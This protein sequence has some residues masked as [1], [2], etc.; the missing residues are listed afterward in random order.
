MRRSSPLNLRRADAAVLPL[1]KRPSRKQRLSPRPLLKSLLQRRR[2]RRRLKQLLRKSNYLLK[3][4]L[5]RFTASIV[6]LSVLG[7][8]DAFGQIG[9]LFS[10]NV[11]DYPS[12]PGQTALGGLNLTSSF[13]NNNDVLGNPAGQFPVKENA[14]PIQVSANYSSLS[15]LSKMGGAAVR[16]PIKGMTAS[17]GLNY[18]ST[19]NIDGYDVNGMP[20]NDFTASDFVIYGNIS[21]KKGNFVLGANVKLLGSYIENYSA[22]AAAVD[23]GGT[24]VHPIED[25]KVALAVKNIGS[26]LK[27]YAGS[28]V[29]AAPINVQAGATYKLKHMPLR[30]SL[31]LHNL[32]QLD[33]V[34]LDPNLSTRTGPD[35]QPIVEKKKLS[36]KIFRHVIIG[37]ELVFSK[38]FAIR[39]G[40][41]HLLRKELK[42]PVAPAGPSGYN[43]GV[44]L[45][46]KKFNL[47]Y[48]HSFTSF[49]AGSNHLGL[50]FTVG[51]RA[52]AVPAAAQ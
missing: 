6:F 33:V 23:L 52:E 17:F 30:F 37:T 16:M 20:T 38:S 45:A 48:S 15:G 25:F 24:F 47:E 14:R 42:L 28:G 50:T 35:G 11:F 39:A 4:R 34:Y 8:V 2:L 36:E 12:S 43:L 29:T 31:T 40:Y 44:L 46:L 41:N 1:R 49:A 32:Q 19:G 3:T 27:S 9:G 5:L 26:G 10:Y 51:A 13:Y 22:Y 21:Q 18:S 7:S